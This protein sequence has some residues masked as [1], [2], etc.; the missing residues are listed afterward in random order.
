MANFNAAVLTEKGIGL[1]AKAQAGQ[2]G[3]EFTRAVAGNGSYDADE[4]LTEKEALKDQRQEFPLDKLSVVNSTTTSIRFTITNEQASGNL[5]E[6]YRVKE[7]GLYATDPDEGEI[8]YAIATAVE[9]QEDFMPA[10][11]SL[12]PAYI[13][14]EFYAEVSNAAHVT[15]VTN[16][17]FITAEEVEAELERLRAQMTALTG[18][19]VTIQD[20]ETEHDALRELIEDAGKVPDG[21]LTSADKGVVDGVASLDYAGKLLGAQ[22][23]YDSGAIFF[24]E[25]L[26]FKYF[27]WTAV[28]GGAGWIGTFISTYKDADGIFGDMLKV[29]GRAY[30]MLDVSFSLDVKSL[31]SR[32]VTGTADSLACEFSCLNYKAFLEIGDDGTRTIK[33]FSDRDLGQTEEHG[34]VRIGDVGFWPFVVRTGQPSY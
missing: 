27:T 30:R 24:G 12:M 11:N 31:Y 6:G 16:G 1:L 33:V 9:G 28:E 20:A 14:V 32:Y 21:V 18:T 2:T 13:T 29:P 17:R 5:L 7:V 19:F 23:P 3:I 4:R 15:I 8:L 10:Y 34:S 25:K 22:I 26:S